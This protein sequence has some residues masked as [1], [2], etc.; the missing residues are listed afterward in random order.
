MDIDTHD[1]FNGDLVQTQVA[2]MDDLE[3]IANFYQTNGWIAIT[4]PFAI[5]SVDWCM[6]FLRR[7]CV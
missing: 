2:T 3:N 5:S 6:V 7:D 4:Q 1:F